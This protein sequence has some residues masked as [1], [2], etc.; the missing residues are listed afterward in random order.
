MP[1]YNLSSSI[2]SLITLSG[3]DVSQAKDIK[4]KQEKLVKELGPEFGFDLN[5]IKFHYDHR[6]KMRYSHESLR[7]GKLIYLNALNNENKPHS[8]VFAFARQTQ[9]ETGIFAIN[10]SDHETNFLLD[11]SNLISVENTGDDLQPNFNSICYIED[12]ISEERGDYFFMREL[13][14]G[15]VNRKIGAYSTICFGF[16]IIPFTQDNYKRTMEK[17]NSRMINEIKSNSG[18]TLDSYQITLQLKEILTKNL[19]LEEFGKWFNYLLDIL[20]KYNT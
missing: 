7:R 8:G 18:N 14:E 15:H 20:A 4:A 13:I 11:L 3:L 2:S 10:F 9:D 6:R 17:S 12:W 5:K 19:P 1:Q 16:Q